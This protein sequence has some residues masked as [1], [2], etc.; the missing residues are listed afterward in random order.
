MFVEPIPAAILAITLPG[1]PSPEKLGEAPL[2]K[3]GSY[4][5][6]KLQERGTGHL[7]RP[8][9]ISLNQDLEQLLTAATKPSHV[10][11]ARARDVRS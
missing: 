5:N 8:A 11:A 7:P 9:A 10:A 1:G 6:T 4:L 2:E 3:M